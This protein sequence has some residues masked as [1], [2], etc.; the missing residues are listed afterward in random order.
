MKA[1]TAFFGVILLAQ[2][3]LASNKVFTYK[4]S[5]VIEQSES[6]PICPQ[7]KTVTAVNDANSGRG[8]TVYILGQRGE[9]AVYNYASTT[10]KCR[11]SI[12]CQTLNHYTNDVTDAK[13]TMTV[14]NDGA[15]PTTDLP[16][17][18]MMK[19]AWV[20]PVENR[21]KHCSYYFY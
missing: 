20:D 2:V 21:A 19:L 13:V 16:G 1:L 4:R 10:R 11:E 8:K 3:T 18:K 14:K 17:Y 6:G 9:T 12:L 7:V 15:Y 5:F